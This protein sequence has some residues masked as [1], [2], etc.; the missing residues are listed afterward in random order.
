MRTPY[1]L[2]GSSLEARTN[3]RA[4]SPALISTRSSG[5]QSPLVRRN[6]TLSV[7]TRSGDQ[8]AMGYDCKLLLV[9]SVALL[10]TDHWD[11]DK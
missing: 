6:Q 7:T 9:V 2:R 10:I 4:T 11:L 1:T 3:H 8:E 5:P